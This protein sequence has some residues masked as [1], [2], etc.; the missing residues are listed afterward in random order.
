MHY[1]TLGASGL[2][3]SRICLGM[4]SYGSTNFQPWL[5]GEEDG[6]RFVRMA[7]DLGINFFDTADFYS[8]GE[9]EVILGRAIGSFVERSQVVIS[10]KVG[11]PLR[12][13]PNEG[14]LSRKHIFEAVD[15][16]LKRMNTDYV[17]LLQMHT[18]DTVTPI[19]ETLAALDDV[20]RAGKALYV[21]GSNFP[22]WRLAKGV[23]H[24]RY[25]GL[26]PISCM[27]LQYNLAYREEEREMLPF[28]EAEGVG[29]TAYS[30]LARGLLAGN[31]ADGAGAAVSDKERARAQSDRKGQHLYGS[32]TDWAI[33]NRL[34]Q[35]AEQ[36][37]VSPARLATAWVAS[38][39]V[40]SSIIL[41]ALEDHHL[42][43]ACAA[44]DLK[45]DADVLR[46]LEEP[47]V[48]QTVKDEGFQQVTGRSKTP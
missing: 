3:V 40:V 1:R 8:S 47:Y 45:L 35:V 37:G 20:V 27:Q 4:L 24:A 43:E 2:R 7:L 30:P 17:D 10:T 34:R 38:K 14:G 25:R 13:G 19:E 18:C 41:G 28:C 42:S 9:S 16:S 21:G 6:R 33:A 29:V 46:A 32:E 44:L 5:L 26:A 15:A 22:A 11:L 23:Y 12:D 36:L 39:P 48:A 31:R